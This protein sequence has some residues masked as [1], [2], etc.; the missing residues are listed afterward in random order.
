MFVY[1][2]CV[3][4]L[5]VSVAFVFTMIARGLAPRLGMLDLPD[6]V[7]KLHV[8]PIPLLGGLA[9]L[10]A[11]FVG[12]G[13]TVASDK[14]GLIDLQLP[15]GF[16]TILLASAAAFCAIGL[17]D[18]KYNLCARNKFLL[19]IIACLP[20]AISGHRI[21]HVEFL[22][23]TL[24]FGQLGIPFTVLW[25]VS[26]VNV[27]NLIDGMDGLASTICLILAMV[28]TPIAIL[29][30]NMAIAMLSLIYAAS[31][32]GFLLHN[33]PPAKI[34]LGDAGSLLIGFL[35]GAL[36]VGGVFKTATGFTLVMPLVVLSVPFFDTFLAIVRR[37]LKGQQISHPDRCH[38]HH[39]LQDRGLSSSQ[40]LLVLTGIC[41]LMGMTAVVSALLK[42]D[43]VALV[44]C[45]TILAIL[46]GAR[47]FARQETNLFLYHVRA[48]HS[49]L[50]SVNSIVKAELLAEKL[51]SPHQNSWLEVKDEIQSN[52]AE[53]CGVDLELTLH[54]QRDGHLVST[55]RWQGTSPA[56]HETPVWHVTRSQLRGNDVCVTMSASGG[57]NSRPA[58]RQM[59][60]IIRILNVITEHWP[61]DTSH[62]PE[63]RAHDY[64]PAE[65]DPTVL[66]SH[67]KTQIV[68]DRLQRAA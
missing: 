27:V 40:T 66:M 22:G 51:S 60:E 12:S 41:L 52:I 62:S 63:S 2:A 61:A 36:S 23:A 55:V 42:T 1:L 19:Q 28:M 48:A 15:I 31:L 32:L 10:G 53:V 8:A 20:F 16:V 9:L 17:Y 21:E 67:P 46:V 11:I 49:V 5:T 56:V 29:N 47:V 59:A 26:C 50:T 68:A 39:Q 35:A 14:F 57:V 6:G 58:S 43:L 33:W 38:I 30:G 25:I 4:I 24:D 34:F 13:V 3:F 45:I 54:D 18:D 44:G 65:N 37:K 7:R 64:Q